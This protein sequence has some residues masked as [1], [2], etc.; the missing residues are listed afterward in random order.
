MSLREELDPRRIPAHVA[1]VMDGNGRWAKGKGLPRTKGHE[2]GER[3]LWDVLQGALEI[4]IGNLTVYAFSTENWVRPKPEVRFLMGF[5]RALIRKRRDALNEQ[6]VRIRFIGRRD[7]RVPRSVVREMEAAE[8]M[9]RSNDRMTLSVALNYGG[10][11]EIVDAARRLL[12]DHAAGRLRGERVDSR[13]LS[14]RM[15]D[16]AVPDPD[17]V[18]RTSGEMRLSNFLVWQSAYAELWFTDVLWPDFSRENLF[19]AVRDYQRRD[20]RFGGVGE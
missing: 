5:N 4:G 19:E 2:A 1:I 18:I 12:E 10:R 11:T 3:A 6:G 16:P 8:A 14:R 15:Y 20:R 7:W 9:T 13:S 17:L